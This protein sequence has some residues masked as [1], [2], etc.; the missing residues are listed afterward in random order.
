MVGINDGII[1]CPE[2]AFGGIKESGIGRKVQMM[3]ENFDFSEELFDDLPPLGGRL[4]RS[5]WLSV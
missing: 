3:R 5:G 4:S 2:A 1:S